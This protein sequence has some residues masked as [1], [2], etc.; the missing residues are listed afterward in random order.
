MINIRLTDIL[1]TDNQ[2]TKNLPLALIIS[3]LFLFTVTSFLEFKL[4][5]DL[6]S[7]SLELEDALQHLYFS[8]KNLNFLMPSNYDKFGNFMIDLIGGTNCANIDSNMIEVSQLKNLGL[9]L[10]TFFPILLL[11]LGFILLLSMFAT[12]IISKHEKVK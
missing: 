5:S 11:I 3:Y 1:E 12:I 2:Y 10:Y 8:Y 4:F 9:N 7:N 6:N